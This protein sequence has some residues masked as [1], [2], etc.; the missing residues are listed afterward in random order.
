MTSCLLMCLYELSPAVAFKQMLEAYQCKMSITFS[1]DKR[2]CVCVLTILTGVELKKK[3]N[4]LGL[5]SC[6]ADY[7]EN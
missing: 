3:K 5:K 4:T 2:E 6:Q 1:V 7:H